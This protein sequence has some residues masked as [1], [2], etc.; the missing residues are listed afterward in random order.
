MVSGLTKMEADRS[1]LTGKPKVMLF[2]TESHSLIRVLNMLYF[3][4][5]VDITKTLLIW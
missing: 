1:G 5:L 3:N 4:T 2:S